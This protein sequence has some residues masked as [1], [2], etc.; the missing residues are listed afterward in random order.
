MAMCKIK[1]S[2]ENAAFRD[3]N[4]EQETARILREIADH[5]EDGEDAGKVMD[6]NG[7]SIGTWSLI[8]PA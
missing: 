7:N 4:A 2:T 1:F 8:I 6:A 5:V 3:G